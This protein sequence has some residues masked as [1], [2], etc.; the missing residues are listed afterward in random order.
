[1]LLLVLGLGIY[2]AYLGGTNAAIYLP[3]SLGIVIAANVAFNI[4]RTHRIAAYR[5]GVKQILQVLVGWTGVF[6]LVVAGLFIFK[7]G[8]LVSRVWLG[9]WF[10]SGALLLVIYRL[11]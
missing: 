11:V 4:A 6:L 5:T 2:L 10:A 9:S 8:D 7:A 3:L 1:G